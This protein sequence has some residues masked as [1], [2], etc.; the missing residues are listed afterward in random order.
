M[1]ADLSRGKA[2]VGPTTT[3]NTK[4]HSAKLLLTMRDQ[5]FIL[6]LS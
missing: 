6:F 2:A 3:S 5:R 4:E 1:V